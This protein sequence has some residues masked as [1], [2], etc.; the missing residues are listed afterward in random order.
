MSREASLDKIKK[1]LLEG[2]N[3]LVGEE[4]LSQ[5]RECLLEYDNN[6]LGVMAAYKQFIFEFDAVDK[7]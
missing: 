3:T 5:A 1:N 4:L 2:P 7:P 6:M